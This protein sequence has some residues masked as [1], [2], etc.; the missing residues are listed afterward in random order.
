MVFQFWLKTIRQSSMR[1]QLLIAG[2]L[3]LPLLT[4]VLIAKSYYP[5]ESKK[6]N[7]LVICMGIGLGI[8]ISSIFF[9][10]SYLAQLPIYLLLS[11]ESILLIIFCFQLALRYKKNSNP[12]P[13]HDYSDG[14]RW[15]LIGLTVLFWLTFTN[16][17]VYYF[18]RIFQNPHGA[19]DAYHIWNLKARFLA[20][21][22]ASGLHSLFSP[23]MN[24]S[25]PDYPLL[26]SGF[27]ARGWKILG[28]NSL[29]IPA[30]LHFFFFIAIIGS[31]YS[32][33]HHFK[34]KAQAQ[35]ATLFLICTPFFI[36]TSTEQ[37][38]DVPLS[39]FFLVGIILLMLASSEEDKSRKR[40]YL[41]GLGIASSL[42]MWTKNEGILFF[43]SIIV[44][45][46][47]VYR[48]RTD[49]FNNILYIVLGALPI[50]VLLIVFKGWMVPANDLV[51]AQGKDTWSR[52]NDFSRYLTITKMFILM[53]WNFGQ[54]CFPPLVIA[55]CYLLITRKTVK[56]YSLQILCCSLFLAI[57]LGLYFL[58]YVNTY[59]NLK[60][61]LIFSLDRLFLQLL[62]SLLLLFF[63]HVA[64]PEEKLASYKVS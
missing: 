4:G 20:L 62:P 48:K 35:L 7:L 6:I 1:H 54:W 45:Y 60:E 14:K 39:F 21:G 32:A 11:I 41:I 57:L 64:T 15:P 12:I 31:L 40:K 46:L 9:F 38:A 58:I 59:W 51:A 44:S 8:G 23:L 63:M 2:I 55:L 5:N 52:I 10:L 25:H 18:A 43:V 17:S 13:S 47:L 56:R 19:G 34:S 29:F 37:F 42:A 53:S 22:D 50:I 36:K 27:I 3:M 61:H 49:L 24:Y 26:I 30:Y 16:T 28:E 33:L